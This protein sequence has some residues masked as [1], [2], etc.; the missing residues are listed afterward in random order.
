M[1]AGGGFDSS[2]TAEHTH[3]AG[4]QAAGQ[5]PA[6]PSGVPADAA[7]AVSEAMANREQNA[8]TVRLS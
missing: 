1:Y 6:A 4:L 3:D 5:L 2:T 7:G 8:R